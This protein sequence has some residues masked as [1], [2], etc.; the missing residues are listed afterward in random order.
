MNGPTSRTPTKGRPSSSPATEPAL[1]LFEGAAAPPTKCLLP[2]PRLTLVPQRTEPTPDVPAVPHTEI[3]T[4]SRESVSCEREILA[5]LDQGAAPGERIADEFRRKEY[6]LGNLFGSLSVDEARRLH[7]RL[8]IPTPDDPI[9]A[10][11]KRL[12]PERAARLIAFLADARRRAAR[13]N[14]R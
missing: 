14:G 5:T 13:T 9:V 1:R 6:V 8:T 12:T 7:Q 3:T 2:A 11:M 4:K 10:R